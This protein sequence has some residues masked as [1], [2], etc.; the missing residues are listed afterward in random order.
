M[1]FLQHFIKFF[2]SFSLLC[3]ANIAV[4]QYNF[5]QQTN[6]PCGGR[7]KAISIDRDGLIYVGTDFGVYCSTDNGETWKQINFGLPEIFI[8]SLA[9][10]SS[11]HIF[12]ET[13]NGLFISTNNGKNWTQIGEELSTCQGGTLFI[14]SHGEIIAGLV[15]DDAFAHGWWHHVGGVYRSI[16]NGKSWA[17]ITDGLIDT[18]I[19][20]FALNS[21]GYIYGGTR[22]YGVARSINGGKSWKH[23]GMDYIST[24]SLAIN[25]SDHIFVGTWSGVYRSIDDG[26][27][28]AQIGLNTRG[29]LSL[30]ITSSDYIFAGT[31]SGLYR[32]IDDGNNWTLAG[33]TKNRILALAINSSCDIFAGA[34]HF[35]LFRST[36]NG[37]NWTQK[38]IGLIAN[39]VYCLNSN[40]NGHIFAG[41]LYGNIF[42]T[43]DGGNNWTQLEHTRSN[44]ITSI[45][46]NP[47]GHI[48]IVNPPLS[49]YAGLPRD[50]LSAIP[51]FSPYFSI[52][53]GK[54]WTEIG[55]PSLNLS[56][57]SLF[58]NSEGHL[59][60]TTDN[61]IYYSTNNG[62]S[63]TKLLFPNSVVYSI[64][65]NLE[66]NIFIAGKDGIYRSIDDGKTWK[67]VNSRIKAF[68]LAINS[69]GHIFALASHNMLFCSTDNGNQWKQ[70]NSD[71]K[72]CLTTSLAIDSNGFIFVGTLSNGVLR[73]VQPTTY[74]RR[75]AGG[76]PMLFSLER[77]QYNP[78]DHNVNITFRIQNFCFVNLNVYDI[79]EI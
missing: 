72:N 53:S 4:S 38:N 18:E 61:G 57:K 40:F 10:N 56:I 12:A 65:I 13:S 51:S 43:R 77:Y 48:F 8:T 11:G 62:I 70:I 26:K 28:W 17:R 36:D 78:F 27:N 24:R 3:P 20:A 30:A 47:K 50:F 66:G 69:S 41:T 23:V 14:G 7:V 45:A 79:W 52:D 15:P 63:W 46:V 35:G 68:N 25:S 5:C 22:S 6:G 33:F 19:N 39:P 67:K 71:L 34:E 54:T 59:F 64:L 76:K 9:V 58:I 55:F 21:K 42:F 1:R 29:I 2:L 16:D 73:S 32:S 75:K 74:I 49:Y 44:S 37:N 31:D 60:V